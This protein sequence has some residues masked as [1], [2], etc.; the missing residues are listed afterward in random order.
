MLE[1]DSSD[2][3]VEKGRKNVN[4]GGGNRGNAKYPLLDIDSSDEEIL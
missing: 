4:R 2:D 1:S 3:E